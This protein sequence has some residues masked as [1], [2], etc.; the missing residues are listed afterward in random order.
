MK[1][2]IAPQRPTASA[3]ENTLANHGKLLNLGIH[4]VAELRTLDESVL[5]SHFGS[6]GRRLY[7]LARGVDE[8]AVIPN[9]PTRSISAEDTFE[10]DVLL[11]DTEPMIRSLS[12]KVWTALRK[13]PRI[14]RTI[15]LKLKTSDFKIYT[16]SVTLGQPIPSSEELSLTALRLRYRTNFEPTQRF[17]LIGVGLSNFRDLSPAEQQELLFHIPETRPDPLDPRENG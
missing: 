8:S 12:E 16:R 7:L 5:T 3:G 14:A 13:E 4:S 1:K 17:R 2:Y 10:E 11:C 15:V 6:Y 9:R